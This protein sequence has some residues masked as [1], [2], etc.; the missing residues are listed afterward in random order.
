[1]SPHHLLVYF[2]RHGETDENSQEIIQ[3]QYGKML[4]QIQLN[5]KGTSQAASLAQSLE[6]VTFN[7]VYCSDLSRCVNTAKP[8]INSHPSVDV[9][10]DKRLRERSFGDFQTHGYA[11]LRQAARE[12]GTSEDQLIV[13]RGGETVEAVLMRTLTFFTEC[14]KREL[15]LG[16]SRTIAVVSHGGPL[17]LLFRELIKVHQVP[18]LEG[19]FGRVP[20]TA[21]SILLVTPAGDAPPEMLFKTMNN[22]THLRDHNQSMVDGP[23]I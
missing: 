5:A 14:T 6:D 21:L 20:N 19:Y 4:L 15:D 8:I 3:G 9:E 22:V 13:S 7:K 17:K 23:T 11:E 2:I 1:M 12:E 10:Y 18:C 16:T